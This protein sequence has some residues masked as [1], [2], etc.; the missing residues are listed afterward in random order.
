MED[1]PYD[2]VVIGGGLA[3]SAIATVM[4]RNEANVLVVE[5]EREFKDRVRGEFLA[6]WGRADVRALGLLETFEAAGAVPLPAL[7]GRS[8]RPRPTLT[9]DGEMNHQ[10]MADR[11]QMRWR[12]RIRRQGEDFHRIIEQTAYAMVVDGR[13]AVMDLVCSGFRPEP[14][15]A[16]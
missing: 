12:C 7:A 3:G 15:R 10:S 9:P 13:I 2:L 1:Q 16:A 4:A 8:L 5:K 14:A 11:V 6:P